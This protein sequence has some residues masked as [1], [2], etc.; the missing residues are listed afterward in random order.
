MRAYLKLSIRGK[1]ADPSVVIIGYYNVTIH[2]HGDTRR[3]LQL[4]WRTT[5]DPEAHFKLSVIGE[6]LF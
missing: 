2:V 3:S 6:Y 4:P 5:S 1:D